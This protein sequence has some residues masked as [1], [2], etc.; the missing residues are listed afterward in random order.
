MPALS[1]LQYSCSART[2]ALHTGELNARRC[3]PQAEK[4]SVFRNH[5]V[6]YVLGSLVI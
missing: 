2:M 3:A 1:V 6:Y 4:H 5:F